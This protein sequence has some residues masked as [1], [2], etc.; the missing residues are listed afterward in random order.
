MWEQKHCWLIQERCRIGNHTT[1]IICVT[2]WPLWLFTSYTW[3]MLNVISRYPFGCGLLMWLYIHD[4]KFLS[5]FPLRYIDIIAFSYK[6]QM[7]FWIIHLSS[8]SSKTKD[9]YECVN[10][11]IDIA[12]YI[13]IIILMIIWEMQP[14]IQIP[15]LEPILCMSYCTTLTK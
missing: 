14:W 2:K 12:D 13:C 3:I 1:V 15:G 10:A 9:V 11:H 4:E 7:S 5:S 8:E 6:E